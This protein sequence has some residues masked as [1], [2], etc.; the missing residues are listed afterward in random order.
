V[1]KNP[2]EAAQIYEEKKKAIDE[3]EDTSIKMYDS[4]APKEET[5][6]RKAPEIK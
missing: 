3:V 6:E 1:I 2:G 4:N 5:S